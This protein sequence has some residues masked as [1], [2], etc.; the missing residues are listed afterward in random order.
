MDIDH[1]PAFLADKNVDST[2]SQGFDTSLHGHEQ[3]PTEPAMLN[4]NG[5]FRNVYHKVFHPKPSTS[6]F[7]PHGDNVPLLPLAKPQAPARLSVEIREL[8][9]DGGSGTVTPLGKAE[10]KE[11]GDDAPFFPG[12]GHRGLSGKVHTAAT[13]DGHGI[14]KFDKS[15]VDVDVMARLAIKDAVHSF[16]LQGYDPPHSAKTPRGEVSWPR[17]ENDEEIKKG[18]PAF[19]MSYL[20]PED[21]L[22][23]IDNPQYVLT[24]PVDGETSNGNDATNRDR[25]VL[26]V[27]EYLEMR[28]KQH[29]K[30]L[31]S[32]DEDE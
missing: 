13:V 23:S 18:K 19:I 2:A 20:S 11:Y 21:R 6:S 8:S 10:I 5:F 7:N 32:S 30:V 15:V 14:F 22:K 9:D 17:D 27:E 31:R 25:F 16:K 24:N 4:Q 29:G 12:M 3:Q 1:K 26:A 28:A